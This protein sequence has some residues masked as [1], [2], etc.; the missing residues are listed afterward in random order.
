MTKLINKHFKLVHGKR[1][2]WS[3]DEH[4]WFIDEMDRNQ[5][6]CDDYGSALACRV[7]GMAHDVVEFSWGNGTPERYLERVTPDFVEKMLEHI[8]GIVQCLGHCH[9][10]G[11]SE[12]KLG[13]L[14][15]ASDA[16][17]VALGTRGDSYGRRFGGND[18]VPVPASG[19]NGQGSAV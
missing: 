13:L 8:D 7:L 14:Q 3:K 1:H 19:D 18:E 17:L 5:D 4:L 9:H 12:E 6:D 15:V 2:L 11:L 10:H 16:L